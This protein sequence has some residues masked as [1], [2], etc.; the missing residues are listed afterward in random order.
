LAR[1]DQDNFITHAG[2]AGIQPFVV[3][4]ERRFGTSAEAQDIDL[5]GVGPARL[6]SLDGS[7]VTV[8]VNPLPDDRCNPNAP[9]Q[10]TYKQREY[11]IDVIYRT[12]SLT[13]RQSAKQALALSAK[14]AGQT[15]MPFKEC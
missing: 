14:D 1:P 8:V 7:G 15:L 11:R 12:K 4:L 6:F 13:M 3:A 9:Y 2:T 10:A 5:P